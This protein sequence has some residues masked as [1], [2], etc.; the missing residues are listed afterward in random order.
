MYITAADQTAH[1][2]YKLLIGSII[3]RPIAFV[4]SMNEQ[5]IVTLPHLVFLIL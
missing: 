5:G 3:P 2:N 4:T 1:D